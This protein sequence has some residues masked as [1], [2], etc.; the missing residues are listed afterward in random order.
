MD[1]RVQEILDKATDLQE[2]YVIARLTHPDAA[3]AA[4]SL[5]L[6]KS[7]IYKWHNF[8]DLEEAV[9]L[10]RRDA[11]EAARLALK[12]LAVDAVQ[13]L[14]RALTG[15][16]STAV[17]AA[18]SILDRIGLPK[19]SQVEHSGTGEDGAIIVKGYV[20]VSPDDWSNGTD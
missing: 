13:A 2:D 3:K 18:N 5:G 1:P 17:N 14:A 6:H 15:K 19:Q 4:R 9:T 10:L 11:V 7:T 20:T 16:G 8:D 12:D